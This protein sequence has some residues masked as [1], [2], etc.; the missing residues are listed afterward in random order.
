LC[1]RDEAGGDWGR[2]SGTWGEKIVARRRVGFGTEWLRRL[3]R[4]REGVAIRE[5]LVASIK[6]SSRNSH[7]ENSA[8]YCGFPI[9]TCKVSGS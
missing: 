9:S 1:V 5:V 3:M 4:R 8:S 2:G 6:K 7:T